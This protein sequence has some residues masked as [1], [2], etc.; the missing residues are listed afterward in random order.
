MA[1]EYTITPPGTITSP[2]VWSPTPIGVDP[3]TPLNGHTVTFRIYTETTPPP[4]EE[5]PDPQP[6]RTYSSFYIVSQ[7][8]VVNAPHTD[9]F[10]DETGNIFTAPVGITSAATAGIVDGSAYSYVKVFDQ[11]EFWYLERGYKPPKAPPPVDGSIEGDPQIPREPYD[12][13]NNIYPTD[14]VT[15]YNPDPRNFVTLTYTLTTEYNTDGS[16]SGNTDV[17]NITQVVTQSITDWSDACK[18]EINRTAFKAGLYNES[19][20]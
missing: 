2:Y 5:V 6:V 3:P 13:A 8:L 17:I 16:S 11:T 20:Q 19:T 9:P 4:S 12:P 1:I 15:R 10:V 7:S 14:A 18:A